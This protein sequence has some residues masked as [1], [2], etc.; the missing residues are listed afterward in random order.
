MKKEDIPQ[1]LGALGKVTK[2][3]CYVVD[4]S[5]NYVTDLSNGW[6]IKSK[7]LDAA[8]EDISE[9]VEAAKTKVIQGAAS[10]LL[11][12]MELK[13]MDIPI[14][15]AY[16][17]IWQWRVRRHLKPGPFKRLSDRT[18]QKYAEAFELKVED[19]KSFKT[20]EA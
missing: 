7:A 4:A 5:G 12:F 18:L 14:L 13:L 6:E 16:T 17:G 15:S 1:D 3:V 9:R 10:P 11:Y 20:H 2:E 8:W 19:I